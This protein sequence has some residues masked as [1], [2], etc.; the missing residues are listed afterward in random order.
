[1]IR[2]SLAESLKLDSKPIRIVVTKV[3]GEEEDMATR[4]YKVPAVGI[5]KISENTSNVNIG[6]ISK[7]LGIL[8]HKLNRKSGPIDLFIGINYSRFHVGHT[9]MGS[10]LVARNSPLG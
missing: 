4:L 1:M 10:D 6:Q 5:P 3:G 2:N 8:K 9:K 7:I